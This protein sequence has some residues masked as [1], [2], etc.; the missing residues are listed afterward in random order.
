M[1]REPQGRSRLSNNSLETSNSIAN[2]DEHLRCGRDHKGL[3]EGLQGLQ[4]R[5]ALRVL[6]T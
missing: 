3:P 1:F 2:E 5:Q 4:G 6:E